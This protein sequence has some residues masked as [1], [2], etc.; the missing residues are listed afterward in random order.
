[1]V[2]KKTLPS[3]QELVTVTEKTLPSAHQ[4][5]SPTQELAIGQE[6]K[7][8]IVQ[9][10]GS[11]NRESDLG[12]NVIDIIHTEWTIL[13][14][15]YN[16]EERIKINMSGN[17]CNTIMLLL[18]TQYPERILAD[19]VKIT[20]KT[21]LSTLYRWCH[22]ISPRP[23]II[24]FPYYYHNLAQEIVQMIKQMPFM[25]TELPI[26]VMTSSMDSF[27]TP[28]LNDVKKVFADTSFAEFCHILSSDFMLKNRGQ[29]V[30]RD[31]MSSTR[32]TSADALSMLG[33]TVALQEC[34]TKSC[35]VPLQFAL[36]HW[37][38]QHITGLHRNN[39]SYKE[40]DG[41]I[42]CRFCADTAT[43]DIRFDKILL[44]SIEYHN[45]LKQTK[46]W[47]ESDWINTFGCLVQHENHST[48]T[49]YYCFTGCENVLQP[50]EPRHVTSGQVLPQFVDRV[51]AIIHKKLHYAV[52]DISNVNKT[53]DVYDGYQDVWI[54]NVVK[55]WR[56]HIVGDCTH[57]MFTNKSTAIV[58]VL[59]LV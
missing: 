29:L 17:E 4:P 51:I 18:N 8:S 48:S 12:D 22:E 54:S 32:P 52:L 3:A 19:A 11:P 33:S 10:H 50:V 23:V 2:T 34:T 21:V 1:M 15:H 20:P 6:K 57:P 56:V 35:L 55:H 59:S 58:V 5:P 7:L 24:R 13:L 49:W 31:E 40:V 28:L 38:N 27:Y 36:K 47:F 37:P 14:V 46:A 16:Q 44:R 25:P 45:Y 43:C 53:I 26:N 39:I 30:R 41:H 9:Q 42:V